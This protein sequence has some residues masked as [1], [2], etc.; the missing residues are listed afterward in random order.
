M[1]SQNLRHFRVFLAVARTSSLTQA[2]E[3]SFVSQPAVTQAIEKLEREAAGPLFERTPQGFF[4]TER[5]KVLEFRIRRAFL[6]LDAAMEDISSRLKMTATWAQLKALISVAETQNFTLAAR[7]L[8]LAQPTIHRAVGRIEAEAATDLFQR[9]AFGL[10]ATRQ[11]R[12]LAQAA[13][14]A[15]AE[16]DQAQADLAEFEGREAGNIVVGALP[17][18]R[19]AILPD[20]LIRY[21]EQRPNQLLT[22]IDGL[23]DDLL[24]GVR[25]GEVDF[26]IGALR[27]PIPIGDIVQ[28]ELFLDR[29]SVLVRPDHPLHVSGNTTAER[30][31][32]SSWVVPR[33]GTPARAQ[34]DSY[35]WGQGIEPPD[36]IIECG[37]V[38]LMREL[39]QGSDMLGC[40]SER[41]A[42]AEVDKGL[43]A[44]IDVGVDFGGRPIGL[45]YRKDWVP[46][47]GQNLL[48]ELIRGAAG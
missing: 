31:S 25:T 34:F 37:S 44:K 33:A 27:D 10:V 5:G 40:I 21:R 42:Q 12:E 32:K 43:L 9:S 47:K 20:A 28:E 2:A 7:R 30:L 36:S 19:S 35:F 39:L 1:T 4:L 22:I 46:T 3:L 23:Y 38:L 16:I 41:Q 18:S 8:G 14:L 11:C 6:R 13:R 26:M 15:F 48:L 24:N 45:T 29:M 17:L